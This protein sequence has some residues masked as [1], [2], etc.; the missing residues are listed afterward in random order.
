MIQ[1]FARTW[2][3][4]VTAALDASR[5]ECGGFRTPI[6]ARLAALGRRMTVADIMY[7]VERLMKRRNLPIRFVPYRGV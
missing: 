5:A 1:V 7:R 6:E 2:T 3:C 4:P